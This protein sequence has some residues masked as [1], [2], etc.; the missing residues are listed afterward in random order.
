M[1]EGPEHG[2]SKVTYAKVAPLVGLH[3]WNQLG[4]IGTFD[5]HRSRI[6][7]HLFKSIVMD[8]DIM[9]MQYGAPPEHG[10]EEARSRFFSPIFNHLVKQFNFMLRNDPE[11]MIDNRFGTLGRIEYFF[12]T[13]GTVAFLCIQ[14]KIMVGNDVE[15]LKII[16]Q[17]I[18]E[19]NRKPHTN[20]TSSLPIHCVF[21]D[22]L[23][24]EFFKFERNPDPDPDHL[25]RG[26]IVSDY[27]YMES[28]LPFILQLRCACETI[29]D[30]MLSAYIAGLKAE[31]GKEHGSTQDPTSLDGWDLALRSADRALAAFRAA[32]VQRERGDLDLADATVDQG[33]HALQESTGAV[34]TFYESNLIM[35]DWD[36]AEVRKG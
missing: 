36:D 35:K 2:F 7:T 6:P 3:P 32:D 26:L 23:T 9:L 24:Y 19:C 33:L 30:M 13:F 14:M 28:S 5:I 1:P 18:A 15:R 10:T 11:T 29:F 12:K 25:R 34:S 31:K 22:G 8:M 27:S 4:D 21:T 17:V 16:A 20:S